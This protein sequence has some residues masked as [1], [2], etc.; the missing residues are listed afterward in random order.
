MDFWIPLLGGALG[1]AIINGVFA[2][3]KL[4]HDKRAEHDQWLR[5]HQL[6][7]YADQVDS[8]KTAAQWVA[9]AY[10]ID[11]WKT[12]NDEGLAI[13]ASLKT[14][15]LVMSAPSATLTAADDMIN[16][17]YDIAEQVSHHGHAPSTPQFAA[18]NKVFTDKQKIFNGRCRTDFRAPE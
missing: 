11:S 3:F 15:Q 12:R 9:S 5:D 18:L 14:G 10:K 1:A 17:L 16:S 2:F 13:M 6:T 7:A 8:T 4:K